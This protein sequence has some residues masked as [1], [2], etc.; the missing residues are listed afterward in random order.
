MTIARVTFLAGLL[1]SV[2]A[3]A[4]PQR[5]ELEK[6]IKIQTV[7]ADKTRV[8][9]DAVAFD[10][11]GFDIK[12]KDEIETVLWTD[13]ET[14]NAYSVF[15]RLIEK[16]TPE[17]WLELGELMLTLEEGQDFSDKAFAR[18]L[19]GDPELKDR[20]EE[21]KS[22][23]PDAPN[24][25]GDEP[26]DADGPPAGGD[27]N[28]GGPKQVGDTQDKF[29]G[30]LSDEEMKSSVEELNAFA[31]E[32]KK[33][34]N[35]NLTLLETKYFLFYSDLKKAEAEKWAGLL[36]RMYNRLCDIFGVPKGT[37]VWRGKALI[38]V[39]KSSSDYH[40]FQETMH[41]TDS[42]GSA[43]MCHS[44]G[45]GLVHIAFYRQDAEQEFAHVLVHESV[46]GYLSRY[47]SP[48]HI[49]SW[50]N[51]GMAEVIASE[52]VARPGKQATINQKARN[53][54]QRA[55]GLSR[56]FFK[57]RQIQG[58][59]YPVAEALTTFMIQQ[60]KKGFVKYINAIKDGE[61]WEEA[62][63]KHYGAT[64]DR[65]VDALKKSLGVRE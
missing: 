36:D 35:G 19:K 34:V 25:A 14:K 61:D 8:V 54:I 59:Q 55:D 4:L 51:E 27:G 16:G 44:F 52:L 31:E 33:Q 50:A 18:A 26:A 41:N 30:K 5:V 37:N 3:W 12:N 21:A 7:K 15:T 40:D 20:I 24:D 45:N 46:H 9:G 53:N 32:T 60:N 6:P 58:W 29:W 57:T 39:F 2:S 22:A 64:P 11:V 49:P 28:A 62:M 47:R 1:I 43:G 17:Q 42:S 48:V 63:V 65:L 13:L 23:K 38:F 56:S 10:A